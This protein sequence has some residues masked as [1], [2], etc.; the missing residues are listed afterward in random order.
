LKPEKSTQWTVGFRIEPMPS[1]SMGFDLWNVQLKD[2]IKTLS[3]SE[4]FLNPVKYAALFSAYY[5]PIQ[6]QDVIAASLTPFNL[7]KAQFQGIDWDHTYR[8]PIPAGYGKL[9]FNWTGTYMMKADLDSGVKGDEIEK[10]V[11]KFN[12]YN[13]VTFR[14]ISR[15]SA[16]WKPSDR[17][18]HSA[19][20]GYH[21]GYKDSVITEDDG[22]IR[23]LNADGTPGDYTGVTRNVKAY[24]TLD[25]QSK[26]N[27]SKNL[28]ITGGIKNLL[29][30]DPPFSQRIEGGGNQLGYD[31]RYTD[32]LGRQFYV[33]G[34]L[35][36]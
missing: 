30:Q 12:K 23:F 8:M 16:I 13:D 6:K 29:N 7:A 15:L 22:A 2:Q 21:S 20:I 1:L 36:F 26:V 33:V 11:G 3:Q 17:Y 27:F 24:Y 19:T 34:N 18:T 10:G 28:T 32:P 14:V 25:L 9:S 31:G 4:V 35:K 5:D